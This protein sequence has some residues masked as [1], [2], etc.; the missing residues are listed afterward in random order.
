MSGISSKAAGT[1]QNKYL[2]NGKEKQ[3]NEFSDGSGLEWYDYGARMQ[4]PQIGMW[5]NID[6]LTEKSRRWSPYNY[7]VDNPIRFIDPDGMFSTDVTKNDDGT[8][9]VVAAK[10]D[11][12]KNVYVQDAKG[13]RTGKVIGKTVTDHSFVGDNG[14]AIKGVIIN[15]S[16]KLGTNF[17]NK[18]I[19]GNKKLGL[20]SYMLN[21]RGRQYYDFKTNGIADRPKGESLTQYMYRGMPVDGVQG[22]ENKDGLHTIA[23]ARDIGNVGAGYMAGNNGLNWSQARMGFDGLQSIQ[24]RKFVAIEGQTTQLAERIGFNLGIENY[25]VE[26]P[27]S[28]LISPTDN[29]FPPR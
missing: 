9:K 16:D 18:E 1:L 29:P 21:A 11:G 14:K 3:A 24:D 13:H 2:F 15:L 19:I 25:K 26:H 8:Y 20:V 7:G 4:D 23:S 6:P 17:L 27:W 10:A 5:H 22:L 12:D 28:S